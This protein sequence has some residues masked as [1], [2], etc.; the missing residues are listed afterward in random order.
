V[1]NPVNFED[2]RILSEL[3]PLYVHHD[4]DN[5]FPTAAGDIDIYAL[6]VRVALTDNLAFIATKEGY[7]DFK[8]NETLQKDH[9]F[10]NIA[11][12]FK[13]S[14]L[15]CEDSIVTLGLK[16]EAPTEEKEVLQGNG[17]GIVNP[18]VSAAT[19]LGDFNLLEYTAVRA[20][21]DEDDSTFYDASLHLDTK[22]GW[23]TPLVEANLFHV[24]QAGDRLPIEDEG[25]DFF[26][27]GSSL[28]ENETM[29]TAAVGG[30]ADL[31]DDL[32][33]GL[34]YEFPLI[35]DSGSYITN[36]RLTADLIYRF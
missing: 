14:V 19:E 8:P 23:F 29:L 31:T 24:L 35:T 26:N 10:A 11:A 13:Y 12:G 3:R 9:G 6:Q 5:K 1:S 32:G 15:A 17:D 16:Y 22:L 25:Q 34:A 21:I 30:R 7:V 20:A 36:W 4:I 18:F 27:I 28:S 33:L 2:P